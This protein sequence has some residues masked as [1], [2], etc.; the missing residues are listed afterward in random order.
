MWKENLHDVHHWSAIF[1]FLAG[2]I[3][4]MIGM[5]IFTNKGFKNNHPYPLIAIASLAE[6]AFSL[7]F[8][9]PYF[10]WKYADGYYFYYILY[11][12]LDYITIY[13]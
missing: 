2:I 3:M 7:H 13:D 12:V 1:L 11:P 10:F 8:C 5:Y 4:F 6:A 9:L